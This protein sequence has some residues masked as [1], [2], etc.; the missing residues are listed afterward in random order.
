MMIRLKPL[1]E[2]KVSAIDVAN[3]LRFE[4]PPV[5]GGSLYLGV[6]QDMDSPRTR[7]QF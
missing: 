5:A 4:A 2:R 6:S 1:K 3:R 7:Q